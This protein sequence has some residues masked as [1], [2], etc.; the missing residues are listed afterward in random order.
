[1]QIHIYPVK[2]LL[3]RE[4]SAQVNKHTYT[5]TCTHTY[6]HSY[7]HTYAN[8]TCKHVKVPVEHQAQWAQANK[9]NTHMYSHIHTHIHT[10]ESTC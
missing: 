8:A 6:T 9:R 5:H 3:K 2:D 1:M 4:H 7:T 10:C